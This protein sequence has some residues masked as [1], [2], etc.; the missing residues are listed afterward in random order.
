MTEHVKY[1]LG[2]LVL[3]ANTRAKIIEV[4]KNRDSYIVEYLD[5]VSKGY[6]GA[7]HAIELYPFEE[8][9]YYML[10]V[11]KIKYLESLIFDIRKKLD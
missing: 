9:R 8:D 1:K 11:E 3:A 2:D 10:L 7:R 5:G 6:Q 4:Q